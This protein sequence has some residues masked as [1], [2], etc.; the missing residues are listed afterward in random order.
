MI[1]PS[2]SE[3]VLG[4]FGAICDRTTAV[5]AVLLAGDRQHADVGEFAGVEIGDRR[6]AR[7][8]VG[9]ADV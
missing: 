1:E 5:L 2:D 6:V 9:G 3:A 7:H 8:V 4:L